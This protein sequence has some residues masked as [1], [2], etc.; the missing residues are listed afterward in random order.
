MLGVLAIT[1]LFPNNVDPAYAPFNRQ[2]LAHLGKLARVEVLAEVPWRFGRWYG[3]GSVKN[4]VREETMDGLAVRHPRFVSIPGL[5]ALNAAFL[6]ASLVR[7]V[8]AARARADVILAAYAYP[9]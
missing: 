4:V 7:D 9:D 3:R 6:A 2:Q 8:R 5:P 1:N